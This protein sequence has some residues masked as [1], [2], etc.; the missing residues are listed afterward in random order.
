MLIAEDLARAIEVD[1]WGLKRYPRD[2]LGYFL[3]GFGPR[4]ELT[5]S[6]DKKH[7][8]AGYSNWDD[9]TR[10]WWIVVLRYELQGCPDPEQE[11]D[12]WAV[13][14]GSSWAF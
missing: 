3:E 7:E 6:A 9:F 11:T 14:S 5:R 13:F 1:Q 10:P 8:M 12:S 2:F 4:W